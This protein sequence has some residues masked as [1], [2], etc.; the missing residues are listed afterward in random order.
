[1]LYAADYSSGFDSTFDTAHMVVRIYRDGE[2]LDTIVAPDDAPSNAIS[3]VL[4]C[5]TSDF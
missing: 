2:Y 1:M 3:W 4:G 5:F